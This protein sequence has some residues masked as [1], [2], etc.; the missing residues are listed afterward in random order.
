[1]ASD[2][3]NVLISEYYRQ[4]I[5]QNSPTNNGKITKILLYIENETHFHKRHTNYDFLFSRPNCSQIAN[6][7]LT[8]V[9]EEGNG[10]D[11][12]KLSREYGEQKLY[13]WNLAHNCKIN[14][15]KLYFVYK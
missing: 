3:V 7:L 1:M 14:K 8:E 15:N 9:L 13:F 5:N 4:I 2:K 12:S 11:Q 10:G 6:V